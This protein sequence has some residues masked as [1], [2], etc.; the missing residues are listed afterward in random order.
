ML[1]TCVNLLQSSTYQSLYTYM[2]F[3]DET[4]SLQIYILMS[5]IKID[6][7]GMGLRSWSS[8]LH[9]FLLLAFLSMIVSF[10]TGNFAN[11]VGHLI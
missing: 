10:Y 11:L 9:N 6:F 3:H 1:S 2:F 8:V 7:C 5:W 4:F